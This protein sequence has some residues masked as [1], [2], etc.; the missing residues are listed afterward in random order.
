MVREALL[1]SV[2]CTRAPVNFQSSQVSMVPDARRLPSASFY[3]SYAG[4]EGAQESSNAEI[5][6][7]GAN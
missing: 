5:V 3:S 4:G 1:A 7:G 6:Y 2:M